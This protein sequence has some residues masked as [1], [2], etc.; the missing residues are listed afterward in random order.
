MTP[1]L[2]DRV[3]NRLVDTGAANKP[4]AL[5]I[6]A[7][8]EGAA[9]LDAYLDN[10]RKV[11]M[12][13]LSERGAPGSNSPEPPGVYVSSINV[14]GFRGV[15]KGVTLS[16]PPGPGLVLIVGR[17]G[18]GKSSFA[19]GLELLLTGRN[20][21]WEKPRA[22]VWQEGWRNLHHHDRVS[23]TAD[24]LVEGEGT[25]TASRV[26][27]SDDILKNDASV[28]RQGQPARPLD[29]IGWNESLAT[30]RPFLSYN[31]LGSL[32]EE[33]PSKLYDALS[34]VLGLEELVNVQNLLAGAR[35]A[36]QQLLD[37]A[38][39]DAGA[40]SELIQNVQATSQDD[41]LL[42]AVQAL[43]WPV[44]EPSVLEALVTGESGESNSELA[45]LNQIQNL[46]RPDVNAISNAV[47]ALRAA[48]QACAAFTG[49]NAER[50]REQAQLLQE[51]LRFHDKH[52]GTECPVCGTANTLSTGWRAK[53]EAEITKLREEAAAY[54][55]ADSARKA[56]VRESQR[57]VNAPPVCLAQAASLGL[58]SIADARR[59]WATWA[60]ARELDT[61]TALADHF[62]T[63]VLEFADAV[64]ALIDDAAA[65]A[66]RREDM[67]RP[68]ALKIAEWLPKSRPALRANERIAELKSAEAWWKEA[69]AAI[70]DERFSPVAERAISIWKQLRLQ[71]NVDLGSVELEGTAQ[72]RRVTLR[73][74]VDGTPA[75]ALGVMSQGELHALALSLFLPRA[76]LSESPFRFVWI[77][78][79]VQSMD[80]A[81]VE[82]LARALAETAKSRQVVVFTHDD[83]LP[84][85][86]RRLGIP[87]TAFGVT[88]R[89]NSVVEVRPVTDPVSGHL[90]DAKALAMTSE[91]PRDVAA[92]VI[93][94][95]C[96]AAVE[97]ACME[98]I[99]RRRLMR[100]ELHDDVEELLA[101]NAKP[102][103]LMALALFDDERK[104][105]D[106]LSRL[107][108]LGKWSA[109]VF[110]AVKA[111]AHV[112]HEGDFDDLIKNTE[113]LARFVREEIQ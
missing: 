15:G 104:T 44:W 18:S 19:E 39:S 106:V 99:R 6:L 76:T 100:G 110:Q 59:Y 14:E 54:D 84:E 20:F 95:F 52:K 55:S 89:A 79:P 57:F 50:S 25:L 49:T 42:A 93:P 85:A 72:R 28:V 29:S 16:I 77:D 43:K 68:I 90:D 56:R 92:R 33:G 24:L 88:R 1:E 61:A 5:A 31:E 97:A 63:H 107:K 27:K 82:G 111:G 86:V 64:A 71:S 38:K 73:V 4:W 46:N 98:K 45:I 83:R 91:L 81:R 51:A 58:P 109:D 78:D 87:A 35:K 102:H 10:T 11:T 80:P 75:E 94:G 37:N 22:K 67:W 53:T 66:K 17:N 74:N 30:F 26:W 3:V 13:Q 41:R 8:L 21:R 108:K 2:Q 23:L 101:A 32:L 36:R 47:A 40:L 69:S 7:A 96:R 34:G 65:E 112:Q 113:K 60:E 103:P 48:E 12:P 105:A 9:D 70:R 62:E